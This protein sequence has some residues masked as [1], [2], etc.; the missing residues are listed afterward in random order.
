[1]EAHRRKGKEEVLMEKVQDRLTLFITLA[2]LTLLIVVVIGIIIL[3][4]EGKEIPPVLVDLTKTISS[5]F[6]GYLGGFATFYIK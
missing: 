2:M 3:T 5:A 1:M 6:V 4:L